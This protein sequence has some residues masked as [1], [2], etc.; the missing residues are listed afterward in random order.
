MK[1]DLVFEAK[2]TGI[3]KKSSVYAL[4]MFGKTIFL[5]IEYLVKLLKN[6]SIKEVTDSYIKKFWQLH[7]KES[8]T[9]LYVSGKE[10]INFTQTYIY[11]SNHSSWMDIP[12]ILGAIPSSVRMVSKAGIM[13]IPLLGKA[14]RKAGF[15]AIDRK[16]R[17]KA[18]KQLDGA[19]DRLQEGISIWMAP[20]G[21]RS[22]NAHI[23]RF[24]KGGFH[25]AKQLNKPIVPVYIEGAAQVM[26]AD[27]AIVRPNQ[28][29]TVHFCE[30]ISANM[31]EELSIN[32][33]ILKVRNSII[34]KS[35]EVVS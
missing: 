25:I 13:Q 21:T 6:K 24:K 4:S 14:M 22:R 10:E 32:D 16:N 29:I 9:N 7:F 30:P 34:E 31:V 18:I 28:S 26:P 3:F 17:S 19:K 33:L 15:I 35:K 27:S 11:M 2:K 20:E 1:K 12:A 5:C 23:A 8:R